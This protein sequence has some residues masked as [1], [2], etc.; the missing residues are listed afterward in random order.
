MA[1]ALSRL[2]AS[3]LAAAHQR[4][5][6]AALDVEEE[7]LR[8]SRLAAG[9]VVAGVLASAALASFGALIV[10]CFWDTARLAALAGVTAL[11]AAA[12]VYAGVRVSLAW[13]GRPPLLSTTLEELRKD[14]DALAREAA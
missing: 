11:Y 2:A 3:A 9:I 10:L 8:A 7:L 1:G 4:L 14:R 6:L 13:S 12:A 5:E